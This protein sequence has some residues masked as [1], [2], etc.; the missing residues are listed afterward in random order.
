MLDEIIR[1]TALGVGALG[2]AVVVIAWRTRPRGERRLCPGYARSVRS[3]LHPARALFRYRC[4]Y[5]LAGSPRQ[6]GLVR[7]SECG[8]THDPADLLRPGSRL[9]LGAVGSL[10]LIAASGTLLV[11]WFQSGR[12]ARALPTLAL[13]VV[14]NPYPTEASEDIREEVSRRVRD[15]DIEGVS[16]RMLARRVA[17]QLRGDTRRGNAERAESILRSLWPESR[18]ELEAL[19]TD[20]DAQARVLAAAIL[21]RR[22][23]NDPSWA[24]LEACIEDIGSC[25]PGISAY[26]R[27]GK[28]SD[29]AEF[30]RAH[31]VRAHPL[32]ESAMHDPDPHRRL[33]AAA[34]AGYAGLDD[35]AAAAAPILISHLADNNVSGDAKLAIPALFRLGPAARPA[36]LASMDAPDPQQRQAVRALLELLDTP[37]A[38]DWQLET[39]MPPVTL[40]TND[41]AR[42][43]SLSRALSD[44]HFR[45][46]APSR[47]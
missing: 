32:L 5:D 19:L 4:G 36:L 20:G 17:P 30:L 11:P 47:D 22:C 41:P 29:A 40:L 35:L 28:C 14:E 2:L 15:G 10:M 37:E 46:P 25:P 23:P 18:P 9:R 6:D 8:R 12:W 13:V 42:T 1:W 16:A 43:L 39:P 21:R 38:R 26:M 34:V 7:C 44:L 27:W 33:V 45:T 31:A 24:L 3:R